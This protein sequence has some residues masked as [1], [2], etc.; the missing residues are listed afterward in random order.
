MITP[1]KIGSADGR[2]RE[3]YDKTYGKTACE[4]PYK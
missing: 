2:P 1:G 4:T 3:I